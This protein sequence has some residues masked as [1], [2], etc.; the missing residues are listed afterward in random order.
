[1]STEP[2]PVEVVQ[3]P[4]LA[5]A[6]QPAVYQAKLAT[7]NEVPVEA[8]PVETVSVE[9][10]PVELVPCMSVPVEV[11]PRVF[12]RGPLR[13]LW[14]T[15]HQAAAVVE[16]CLG[17]AALVL[18]LALLSAIPGFFVLSLGY[19]LEVT[20]RIGRTGKISAG[21]V[22]VR[23]AARIGSIL[24]G[25]W[26]W[27]LPLRLTVSWAISAQIIAEGSKAA[28]GWAIGHTLLSILV[29]GHIIIACFRGGRLWQ[30]FWPFPS[31]L[32]ILRQ[33]V[34]QL[35]DGWQ[36]ENRPEIS[37]R[38]VAKQWAFHPLQSIAHYYTRTRDSVWNFV[39]SLRLPYY[40]WLGSRGFAGTFLWLIIPV[41]LL[42]AGGRAPVLGFVGAALLIGVVMYLPYL[43]TRF[44]AENRFAAMFEVKAVRQ[45]F[46]LAPIAFWLGLTCTLLFALP[47]Y[48]LKIEMIPREVA[49]LPNLV[50][51]LFIVPARFLTGWAYGR[52]AV[53][54]KKRWKWL[55]WFLGQPGQVSPFYLRWPSR[56][57]IL[58]PAAFYVLVLFFTQ[59]TA[60]YGKLSLYE[61]HAFLAPVPFLKM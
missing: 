58:P 4:I 39:I 11:V 48:L 28:Q 41:T 24:L 40:F 26:L 2:I 56:L 27:L 32:W 36:E 30:F 15:W 9:A 3:H 60:W 7:A 51:V 6:V 50:F 53:P 10:V 37:L 61:Q 52:A 46:R 42:A 29:G 8:V 43:Q 14:R 25:A 38:Q 54:A 55:S 13:W 49:W 21:F 44:A 22:G 35:M 59:Y 57:A 18:G 1:M 16:W 31:L 33:L 12:S 19:L 20:G 34:P 17:V 47:L 23:K 5:E 45:H